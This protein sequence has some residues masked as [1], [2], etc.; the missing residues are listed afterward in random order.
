MFGK[1]VS[2]T[3]TILDVFIG[4]ADFN[5]SEGEQDDAGDNGAPG[6]GRG[7]YP[8]FGIRQGRVERRRS[9]KRGTPSNFNMEFGKD[10][11]K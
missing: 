8:G 6:D 1:R 9:L 11:V 10:Q 2:E 3:V 4:G 5:E 7:G